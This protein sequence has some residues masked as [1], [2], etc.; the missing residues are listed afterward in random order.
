MRQLQGLREVLEGSLGL[1][2]MIGEVEGAAQLGGDR[3]RVGGELADDV[4]GVDVI[5]VD[6]ARGADKD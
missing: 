2:V 3:F 5:G 4:A 1:E 6:E